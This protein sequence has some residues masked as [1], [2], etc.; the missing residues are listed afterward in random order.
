MYGSRIPDFLSAPFFEHDLQCLC[1]FIRPDG[2]GVEDCYTDDLCFHLNIRN[3][4]PVIGCKDVDG[5]SSI[6]ICHFSPDP[7]QKMTILGNRK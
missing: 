7:S 2:L 1:E 4:R 6:A 5:V 3:I